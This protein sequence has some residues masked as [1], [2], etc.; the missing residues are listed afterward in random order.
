MLSYVALSQGDS[1]GLI[2]FSDHIHNY[3][4]PT[5]G[6]R[7]MNR[8]LHAGFNQFP[9]LVQ[10]RF[11]NAFLYLS[12]HCRRRSLV[13]L[14]TNVIDQVNADQVQNY[15]GNLIGCHLPLLVLLRD[16][17]LFQFADNPRRMKPCCIAAPLPANSCSGGIMSFAAC[18][19]KAAWHWTCSPKK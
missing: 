17:S 8:L 12:T 18:K 9:R 7:Q 1:V 2:C 4:P 19:P 15:M 3:V 5:G 14:V 11:D 6:K 16:H 10:S 13:V